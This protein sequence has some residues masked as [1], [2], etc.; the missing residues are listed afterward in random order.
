M[1]NRPIPAGVEVNP[2][3]PWTPDDIAGYSGEVVSAMTVLEPLLRSGLLALHPDEWQGG[4]FSF[5]RPAQAR[6][7]GWTPP[8]RER[9]NA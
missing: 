1:K 3:R 8:N 6:L 4:K 2:N 7:Q 5:L 9:L